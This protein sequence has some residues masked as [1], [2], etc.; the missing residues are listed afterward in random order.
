MVE[1]LLIV[2]LGSIGARHARLARE[3]LPGVQ[4]VVLRHRGCPEKNAPGVDY[5][6]TGMDEALSYR[7]QAAVIANPATHHLETALPLARAGVHLLVEK[8][9][10]G[11][12]Q[13]VAELI[14]LCRTQG[15]TLMTGYN[16][17][18]LPSLRRFRELLEE[19]RVGRVLSVR[20]EIGQFL[21][22]CPRRLRWAAVCYWN[23]ATRSTTCAGC[24]ARSNG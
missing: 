15:V 11:A 14:E 4:L 12:T 16:L 17:R 18:F 3:L 21:P 10:S 7:P 9:I 23:S 22:A 1:R 13:G 5:C 6:V 2:G 24:S 20:A 19:K 8:P